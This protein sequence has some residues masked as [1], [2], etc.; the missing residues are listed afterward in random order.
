M[1]ARRCRSPIAA[2]RLAGALALALLLAGTG[3][4]AAVGSALRA[5]PEL[6]LN[7]LLRVEHAADGA[8]EAEALGP[9]VDLR[10]DALGLSHALRPLYQHKLGS[11]GTVTDILA[12]F[13]RRFTNSSGTKFR[14]WPLVWAGEMNDTPQGSHWAGVFFP[15]VL[16]GNG[17]A[18]DD[19]Y[20]A[21]FPLAGRTR[22]VFGIDQ[23]DF[24]LWP[25]F[26]RTELRVSEPSVSWTVLLGGG[27]TTG[28]PRDGSWRVL[29]FYRHRLWRDSDGELRTDQHTVLW[30]FFTWGLDYG[31]SAAPSQRF[32]FWPFVGW[33]RSA[34]WTRLT[35]LWPFFRIQRET[36]TEPGQEPGFLYDLPWPFFRWQRGDGRTTF[37]IFPFYSRQTTPE[38]DSTSFLFPLGW[39]RVDRGRTVP[40]G[41]ASRAYERRDLY[42]LPFLHDSRR[43]VEDRPGADTERQIWPLYHHDRGPDGWQD[44]GLLSLVPGRNIEFLKPVDELWSFAWSLWRQRSDGVTQETRLLFDL[45]LWRTGPQ[46]TRI[47]VPLL[48][49]QRPEARGVARHQVLWGLFG[50]RRDAQGLA[51]L[52]VLGF[53][54]WSR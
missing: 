15:F 16:A 30:P 43:V 21:F 47:S 26:M 13:G 19:G 12:P 45:I 11:A 25:L 6:D 42:A 28:G 31:D 50:W 33:E 40:E 7:P 29:P 51:A 2:P 39:W 36:L 53:S 49:S 48:Y 27:W 5:L 10:S 9:L 18:E 37:R 14:F 52:D 32:S 24:L 44:R 23:F 38:L 54:P 22:S 20:F 4:C 3:G 46:G 41:T 35:I 1:D 17:P 8:V 34:A